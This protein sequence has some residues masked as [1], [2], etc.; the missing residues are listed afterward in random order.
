MLVDYLSFRNP[1]SSSKQTSARSLYCE[2]LSFMVLFC[3]NQDTEQDDNND[4]EHYRNNFNSRIH[5]MII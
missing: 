5:L 4:T 3:K 2:R 1:L